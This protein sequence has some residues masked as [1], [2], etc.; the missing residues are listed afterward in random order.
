[1]KKLGAILLIAGTCIGSGMIALPMVLAKIGLI[2][3]I[4]LMLVIWV[5]TYYT[6]LIHLELNLQ[7]GQGL[8]LGVLA[9]QFSGRKANFVGTFSVKVLSYSL[10]AVFIYGGASIMQEWISMKMGIA[11]SFE[12]IATWFALAVIG[13]LLLPIRVIDYVNRVL[14]IGMIAVV[15]ILI[16]G[17]ATSIQWTDLPLFSSQYNEISAWSILVPVVFTSFGFQVISHTLINYCES[18]SKLLKQVF[19][20]GS[21]IPAIVYIVWT[22]SVLSVVHHEN[23]RFYEQMV[24]GKAKVGELIQVLSGIAKWQSVQ[25]LV[26]LISLLAIVT[27]V[28]GVGMG[29]FDSLRGIIIQSVPKACAPSFLAALSTVIP[30]YLTVLYVPNAFIT[31][32]GFA[33]MISTVIAILLPIYLFWKMS[34]PHEAQSRTQ[35]SGESPPLM[36]GIV[37]AEQFHYAEV[38][39]RWL[40]WF[41]ALIGG[42]VIVCELY[43]IL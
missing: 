35:L 38:N 1:M 18:R 12:A 22:C 10:I 11:F 19:F 6:S 39:I 8:P 27:S 4:A 41:S 21:L 24:Q 37:K 36:E 14:F 28:I 33:G 2:P 7:A 17:L 26:W 32:L 34:R 42:A 43:N 25:L 9:R 40:T 23:A 5:V 15:L 29:L 31:M 20:W 13:V 3:G 16:M 30:A